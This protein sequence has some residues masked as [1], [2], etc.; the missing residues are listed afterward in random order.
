[1]RKPDDDLK[2]DISELFGGDLPS[3]SETL[4]EAATVQSP[5]QFENAN[6]PKPA[7]ESQFQDWMS[8]R[9]AELEE[10]SQELEKRLQETPFSQITQS[11]TPDILSSQELLAT[12]VE[13]NSE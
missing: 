2:I 5:T 3:P 8:G 11:S 12:P 9:N 4:E 6:A 13:N 7:T 10:K 1:M